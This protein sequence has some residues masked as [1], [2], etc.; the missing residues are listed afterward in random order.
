[1]HQLVFVDGEVAG[2]NGDYRAALVRV[3]QLAE[4][5]RSLPQVAWVEVLQEPVNV[6]SYSRLQGSTTDAVSAVSM[7]ADFKLKFIL[8]PTEGAQ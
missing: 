2:F 8:R 6:S 7:A 5:L 4:K 1:L 3:N